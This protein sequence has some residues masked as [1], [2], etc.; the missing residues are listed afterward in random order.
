MYVA[1]ELNVY[2][3]FSVFAVQ[4]AFKIFKYIWLL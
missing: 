2:G 4:P 1:V 3:N